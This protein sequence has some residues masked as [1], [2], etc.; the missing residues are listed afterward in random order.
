MLVKGALLRSSRS[1]RPLTWNA[2]SSAPEPRT[3]KPSWT[4]AWRATT[5]SI[6]ATGSAAI[7]SLPTFVREFDTS[8]ST[9]GRSARTITSSVV[10]VSG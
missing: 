10:V 3:T 7:S 9:G 2:I 4:P 8:T 5:F 6:E 1:V